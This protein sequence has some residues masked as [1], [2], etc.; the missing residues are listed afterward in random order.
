MI[1]V[2]RAT[3]TISWANPPDIVYGTALSGTQLDATASVQGTLTY[4]PVAG[5]V[6]AAGN[7]QT[8]SVSF[9]P[10]DTTDYTSASASVM[11][12]VMQAT[13]TI[14]WANP[15]D[16]VFGTP[17]G[18]TQLDATASVPGTFTYSPAAGTV[19]G[20]GNNQTLSVAFTP[21]DTT[22]YTT[23]SATT[24]INVVQGQAIPTISW[25]NPADIVY[26][27]A[28]SGTQLDATASVA[29][30]FTYTP[31]AGTVLGAG[32][33]QTIS[34]NLH[35]HRHDRL[36]HGH[37]HGDDQRLARDADDL[38]GQSS[39]YCLRHG[40]ERNS[41]RRHGQCSW[42]FHLLAGRRH[43]PWRRQPPDALGQ[44]RSE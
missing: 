9:A 25:A 6:L 26:G 30:T 12:N 2:L 32:L 44:L 21:T 43:G 17:L 22:D 36:Y 5:M 28:L 20:A 37:G 42:D 35:P 27:T 18:A 7:D 4:T 24:T 3:P 10:N 39:R 31:A 19:L 23:A 13:P 8:L 34:V 16:I 15:A 41:T 11:I 40:S 29:G 1:N 33:D 38:L 14:S